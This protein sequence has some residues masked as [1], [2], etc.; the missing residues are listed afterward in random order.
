MRVALEEAATSLREGDNGLG[1]VL[2][3]NGDPGAGSR[4]RGNRGSDPHADLT[5]LR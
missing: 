1:P 3:S 2:V 4:P 5:G